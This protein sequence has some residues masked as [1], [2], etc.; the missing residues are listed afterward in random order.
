MLRLF[1]FIYPFR[2][3]WNAW[4]QNSAIIPTL[5]MNGSNECKAKKWA[6]LNR[7]ICKIVFPLIRTEWEQY[8]KLV[9]FFGGHSFA[10]HFLKVSNGKK[11]LWY[12]D[13]LFITMLRCLFLNSLEDIIDLPEE[14]MTKKIGRNKVWPKTLRNEIFNDTASKR[15]NMHYHHWVER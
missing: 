15:A 1:F 3:V 5:G 12:Q 4:L 7:F 11:F 14:N 2:F 13:E 9:F 8:V 6:R 10:C